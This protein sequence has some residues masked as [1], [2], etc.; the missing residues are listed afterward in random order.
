MLKVIDRYSILQY[1]Q[2]KKGDL[3]T[4]FNPLI[5]DFIV[6]ILGKK[7]LKKID[8]ECFNLYGLSD[9]EI[10]Y[11]NSIQDY[12]RSYN[13]YLEGERDMIINAKI[14]IANANKIAESNKSSKSLG[15]L[16]WELTKKLG[17]KISP[18]KTTIREFNDL[19]RTDGK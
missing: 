7:I 19:M 11:Y 9:S 4:F 5:P 2:A 15:A 8:D 17:V 1:D 6:K 12:C 3:N 18:Q 16:C 14:S 10:E 13:R